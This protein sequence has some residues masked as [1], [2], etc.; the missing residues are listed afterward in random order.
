MSNSLSTKRAFYN[1]RKKS[2]DLDKLV[3]STYFSK[4][5]ISN[6][7]AGRRTNETIVNQAYKLAARRSPTF[8]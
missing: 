1:A 7:L 2:G 6:V 5:H 8:A 4:P 3:S